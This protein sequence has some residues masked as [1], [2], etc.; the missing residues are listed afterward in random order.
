[1]TFTINKGYADRNDNLAEL[2]RIYIDYT[3]NPSN[4]FNA[5]RNLK[6]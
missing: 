3:F 1:M 6:K 2:S 5:V 4:L